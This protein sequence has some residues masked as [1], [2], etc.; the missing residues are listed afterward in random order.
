MKSHLNSSASEWIR[1]LLISMEWGQLQVQSRQEAADGICQQRQLREFHYAHVT[2]EHPI[3]DA[4]LSGPLQTIQ[5]GS[6]NPFA[7]LFPSRVTV[8]A[9]IPHT[10]SAR[11]SDIASIACSALA[12]KQ[13]D[14]LS[15]RVSQFQLKLRV[16]Q[17]GIQWAIDCGVPQRVYGKT[18][19]WR[20]ACE[21]IFVK[22]I[23]PLYVGIEG[24]QT[25]DPSA[26]GW[27][28]FERLEYNA[29]SE[30]RSGLMHEIGEI[31]DLL[32][33]L[34][35]ANQRT[36]AET[37]GMG[38]HILRELST[39]DDK[40]TG[41]GKDALPRRVIELMSKTRWPAYMATDN[42]DLNQKYDD[43]TL[44]CD[45]Y[46]KDRARIQGVLQR[47]MNTI[48]KSSQY[49][50]I[51]YLCETTTRLQ[52][53][54][55]FRLLSR[56]V[57]VSVPTNY[58][59]NHPTL[60]HPEKLAMIDSFLGSCHDQ[61]LRRTDCQEAWT[62]SLDDTITTILRNHRQ[63]R[64]RDKRTRTTHTHESEMTQH[65]AK[66]NEA[67]AIAINHQQTIMERTNR[68]KQNETQ[69]QWREP[70]K[71]K[72]E[73]QL[74]ISP[75]QTSS[76][77][78]QTR[79][80]DRTGNVG[81]SGSVVQ[82]SGHDRAQHQTQKKIKR[83]SEGQRE[84]TPP[85]NSS[86]SRIKV[87][88]DACITKVNSADE[89]LKKHNKTIPVVNLIQSQSLQL[90]HQHHHTS[91]RRTEESRNVNEEMRHLNRNREGKHN[92]YGVDHL[93]RNPDQVEIGKLTRYKEQE[94]RAQVIIEETHTYVTDGWNMIHKAEAA[95]ICDCGINDRCW[96]ICLD[97][98]P[99]PL[100]LQRCNHPGQMGHIMHNSIKHRFTRI[101]MARIQGVRR[102]W[103]R[104]KTV[105]EARNEDQRH[106]AFD[107]D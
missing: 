79:I 24:F 56:L 7:L 74:E 28:W 67:R 6:R 43:I 31:L 17:A 72:P 34:H 83:E 49:K 105:T 96:A 88:E 21:E 95:N 15:R 1:A 94:G 70:T 45:L 84:V 4:V 106:R 62:T 85:Q 86:R 81:Q 50:E 9:T 107:V 8:C 39:L 29:A 52:P 19:E 100:K 38:K 57:S 64:P 69:R 27:K 33:P 73:E 5:M 90:S 91:R 59:D 89:A 104:P 16:L 20:T 40:L 36:S 54:D 26:H 55:T 92:R 51:T 75:F 37:L 30:S 61:W 60:D 98:R 99:W 58:K 18:E 93:D 101:Q 14:S 102:P 35:I 68:T 22:G 46:S 97:G 66:E 103:K 42:S 63:E 2:L 10:V 48:I 13:G 87:R 53:K 82:G 41:L 71:R 47:R 76:Q 44:R 11:Y 25:I 80:L 23:H 32:G 65:P 77:T 78:F 3:A 12:R